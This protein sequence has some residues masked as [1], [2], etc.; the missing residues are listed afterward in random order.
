LCRSVNASQVTKHALLL[1]LDDAHGTGVLGRG[2]GALAHF[3]ISPEPWIVQMGTF[4]KACGSFGAF[5]AGA[6][7]VIQWITSTARSLLFSTAIPP[8]AV[9]ASIAAI[10]IIKNNP[11]FVRKL[12]LNRKYLLEGLAGLGYD[13]AGTET[14]IIPIMTDSVHEAV[15]LSSFLFEH[16]CYVPAI[17]PP[18]VKGPRIR[19]T[20][21]AA[22][23]EMHMEKLLALLKAWREKR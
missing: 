4:S 6:E 18:T 15:S 2:R 7:D 16:G 3:D 13:F 10:R 8:S 20:V 11:Q 5:C 17:R 22:H 14:P 21:S 19:I 12:W 23:E 1:Y 9:A